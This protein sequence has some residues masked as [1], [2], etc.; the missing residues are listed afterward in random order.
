MAIQIKIFT[1]IYTIVSKLTKKKY[2]LFLMQIKKNKLKSLLPFLR[3]DE[4]PARGNQ[5]RSVQVATT[6]LIFRL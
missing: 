5:T 6:W 1:G 4:A 3:V 2:K